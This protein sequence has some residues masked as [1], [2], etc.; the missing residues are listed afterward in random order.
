MS[1]QFKKKRITVVYN[2]SFRKVHGCRYH[3]KEPIGVNTSERPRGFARVFFIV[4]FWHS[5][6]L[7]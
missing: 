6:S 2:G 4:F 3:I 5:L 7:I 1:T